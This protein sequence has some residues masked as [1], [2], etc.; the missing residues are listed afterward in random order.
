[1]LVLHGENIVASRKKLAEYIDTA[2]SEQTDV[3]RLEAKRTSLADLE[4]VLGAHDL[5]GTKKLIVIEEL[6]SL[7]RSKKKDSLIDLLSGEL[8]HECILWEKRKLTKTMLRKFSSAT[9]SE[10]TTSNALFAWL[11]TLGTKTPPEKKIALLREA[12]EKDGEYL[13]FIM[14]I[15]QIR[16]LLLAKTGGVIK[17]PPFMVQKYK[18]QATHFSEE[19]LLQLHSQLV[20]MDEKMKSTKQQLTLESQLDLFTVGVYI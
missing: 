17:G 1:M 8:T 9:I 7:P 10:H 16:Y 15:R 5:F 18:K 12:A 3:V 2:R 20:L 11:D 13:C 4:S 6:H 19:E 14:L